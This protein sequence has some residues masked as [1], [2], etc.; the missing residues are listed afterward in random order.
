MPDSVDDLSFIRCLEEIRWPH[1]VKC[2]RCERDRVRRLHCKGKNGKSRHL[3]WCADC[4]Y[5]FSITVGTMLQGS[6][7][8][9][10]KWFKA[11]SLIHSERGHITAVR[12]SKEIGVSYESAWSV[13][14]RIG[15]AMAGD[16]AEF[17]RRIAAAYIAL[18]GHNTSEA[19]PTSIPAVAPEAVGFS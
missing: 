4:G 16:E 11:I 18:M 15:K 14:K 17:C 2:L 7:L 3:Y 12:L 10:P 8:R 6:H 1:K 5:E 9:L 19:A 13:S